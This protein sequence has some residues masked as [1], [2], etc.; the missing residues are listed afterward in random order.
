[1][2]ARGIFVAKIGMGLTSAL[3]A[4]MYFSTLSAWFIIWCTPG[5]KFWFSEAMSLQPLNSDLEVEPEVADEPLGRGLQRR[6]R[7]RQVWGLPRQNPL[8]ARVRPPQA[9]RLGSYR[10]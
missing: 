8:H 6:G 4:L 3:A 1:M 5:N 10:V 7:H 2:V 9:T